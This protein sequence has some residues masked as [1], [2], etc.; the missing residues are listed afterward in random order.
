MKRLALSLILAALIAAAPAAAK[1]GV[2][3]TL[4]TTI[5]V[6]A[7][8]GTK[9]DAA[10]T[11]WLVD[12][13][14]RRPFGAGDVF[15]RLVSATGE[16]SQTAYTDG[17]GAYSVTVT[18]PKGGIGDVQI[19]LRGFSDA[20]PKPASAD[21]LFPIT[22][23]P[24]PGPAR[25]AARSSERGESSGTSRSVVWIPLGAA[26]ALSAIAFVAYRRRRAERR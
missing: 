5:P 18:V 26:G 20:S 14:R 22:N 17:S 16:G 2:K 23:D 11:L 6:G 21:M 7:E 10:W 13:G 25:V 8:P 15:I 19:G 1:E 4:K 9:V 12:Q 24:M 3:A